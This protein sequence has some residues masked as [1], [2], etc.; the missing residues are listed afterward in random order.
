[1]KQLQSHEIRSRPIENENK[2]FKT[3]QGLHDLKYFHK[4]QAR[5][6]GLSAINFSGGDTNVF[7]HIKF[8]LTLHD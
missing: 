7:W 8:I 5:G 4:R 2:L 6:Y 1:M 3:G